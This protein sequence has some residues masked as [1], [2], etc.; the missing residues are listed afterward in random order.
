[1][2]AEQ[3]VSADDAADAD[4]DPDPFAGQRIAQPY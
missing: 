4:P 3:G 2:P 1:M